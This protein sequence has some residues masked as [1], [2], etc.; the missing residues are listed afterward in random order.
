M[1]CAAVET[2]TCSTSV[3][4]G[5]RLGGA[6]GALWYESDGMQAVGTVFAEEKMAVEVVTP[7]CC[8]VMRSAIHAGALKLDTVDVSNN[9][10]HT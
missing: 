7:P 3:P 1:A 9:S 5:S 2:I 4:F 8:D 10:N 6:I